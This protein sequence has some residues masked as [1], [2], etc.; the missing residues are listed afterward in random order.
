MQGVLELKS[1][2][3][4]GDVEKALLARGERWVV[5]VDEA[6]RGPLAGP[7]SVGAVV[8]DLQSLDWVEGLNDSKQLSEAAREALLPTVRANAVAH[9]LVMVEPDEIDELNILW[10]SMEGMRR[11]VTAVIEEFPE[12]AGSEVLVD[13]NRPIPRFTGVQRPL[14]KGDS[15]SWAIAA[16]S[17]IAKVERDRLM[18]G[19]DQEY[20]N[21]GFAQHKGYPTKQHLLALE[22]HGACP[23][24]RKTFAPVARALAKG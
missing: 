2:A 6:G 13:G 14:V 12:A 10:A 23:H 3:A 21:Y 24:H 1:N 17:I 11:A 20:P 18:V 9:A 22:A 16:A 19:L 5:G 7:V 8:L 15:R 4:I